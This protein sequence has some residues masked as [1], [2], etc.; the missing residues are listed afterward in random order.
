MREEIRNWWEQAKEDLDSAEKNIIIKKYYLTAFM[1]QQ[2]CEK[3]LKAYLMLKDK[4][5]NFTT[6]SLVELGKQ[7]KIPRETL[8]RLRNLAPQ[9]TIARYP[10]VTET[11]PY[12]NYSLE[13]S[14]RLLNDAKEIFKWLNIQMKE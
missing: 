1:A 6:H 12:E 3:G 11:I 14:T 4:K 13:I 9:Y 5:K 2:A 8:E 7:A 10:D